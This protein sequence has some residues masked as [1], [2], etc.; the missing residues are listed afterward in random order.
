V[1]PLDV[2][3]VVPWLVAGPPPRVELPPPTGFAKWPPPL[4]VVWLELEVPEPLVVGV[5]GVL[6]CVLAG[7]LGVA[8][9][10]LE[11]LDAGVVGA[12]WLPVPNVPEPM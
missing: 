5:A 12:G 1:V 4:L 2:D 3:P 10:G 7:V 11:L 8:V 9:V 6:G